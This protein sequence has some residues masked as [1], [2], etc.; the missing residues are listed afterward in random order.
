MK[1]ISKILLSLFISLPSYAQIPKTCESLFH[2][3]AKKMGF[4]QITEGKYDAKHVKNEPKKILI[5]NSVG[6][7]RSDTGPT[8]SLNKFEGGWRINLLQVKNK[9]EGTHF[10]D[11]FYYNDSCESISKIS[12]T[13][14]TTL[15]FDLDQETCANLK[16]HYSESDIEAHSM[17]SFCKLITVVAKNAISHDKLTPKEST[18]AIIQN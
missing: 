1:L 4:S 9:S 16:G 13:R 5:S 18:N 3:H 10:R 14:S 17:E 11:R 2:E 6:L 7:G 15:Q 12:L 8:A